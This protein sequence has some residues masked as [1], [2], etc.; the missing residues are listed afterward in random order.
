MNQIV[1]AGRDLDVIDVG[2]VADDH[3]DR[4]VDLMAARSLVAFHDHRARA[5]L[6]NHQRAGEH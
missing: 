1:G 4:G 3:L 6:D 5:L 2:L